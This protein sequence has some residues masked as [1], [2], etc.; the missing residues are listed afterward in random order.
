MRIIKLELNHDTFENLSHNHHVFTFFVLVSV[1]FF[2][3]S[4]SVP[5]ASL[6]LNCVAQ[7][8]LEFTILLS[9][10]PECWDYRLVSLCPTLFFLFM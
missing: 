1:S 7:A 3:R 5:Q 8:G 2:S 4:Y 10:I 9:Q 6:E